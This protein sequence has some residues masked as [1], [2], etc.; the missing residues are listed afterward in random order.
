MAS[1]ASPHT[2]S[3]KFKDQN[4]SESDE[5]MCKNCCEM[6]DHLEVLISELKSTQIIIQ[7]L[8]EDIKLT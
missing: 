4:H 6:K 8:Q 3:S 2:M 5:V 7:L 1:V